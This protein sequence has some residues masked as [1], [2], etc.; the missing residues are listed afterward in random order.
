M[1][2]DIDEQLIQQIVFNESGLDKA[3]G[4]VLGS[5][6]AAGRQQSFLQ[7]LSAFAKTKEREIE[8]ISKE[9]YQAPFRPDVQ[10]FMFLSSTL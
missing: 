4:S 9:S 7:S 5:V 6:W 3:L 10:P 8:H 1:V 2:S